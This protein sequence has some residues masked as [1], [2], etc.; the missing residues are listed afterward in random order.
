MGSAEDGV[1]RGVNR[2]GWGSVVSWKP[3]KGSGFP[4]EQ[5]WNLQPL[6]PQLGL[7]RHPFWHIPLVK[8]ALTFECTCRDEGNY[9]IF[10]DNP[11]QSL[12]RAVSIQ[13]VRTPQAGSPLSLYSP[14][15]ILG[16]ILTSQH[17]SEYQGIH[18]HAE[19][20]KS[21]GQWPKQCWLKRA[22]HMRVFQPRKV[23]P[24]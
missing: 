13:Q 24:L 16:T 7:A 15:C 12:L 6:Q 2:K 17:R 11:P 5:K 3:R 22:E 23:I 20:F 8:A 4:R 14:I 1:G 10:A 21:K 9:T 18:R 19:S